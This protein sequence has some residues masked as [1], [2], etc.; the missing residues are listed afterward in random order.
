MKTL[1]EAWNIIEELNDNAHNEA[2]DTWVQADEL[3][4]SDE[5]DDWATAEDLREEASL[6]QAEHFRDFWFDL[7]EDDQN[8]VKYWLK[9]DEDF[10]EQFAV[11]FGEDE[12]ENEFV[13]EEE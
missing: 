12:F 8:L 10:R 11:Y 9:L 2:W 6:Q 7:D 4:E 3:M 13:D 1:E 5:E